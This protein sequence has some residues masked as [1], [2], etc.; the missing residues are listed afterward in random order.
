[1]KSFTSIGNNKGRGIEMMVLM[2][3][4][5]EKG[6]MVRDCPESR[7]FVFGKPKE[8]NKE[9]R[10]K[11]RAQ[12]Q[13]FAMTHRD[14]QATSDVV[15]VTFSIPGQPDFSFEGKHVDKP[16]RMIS[17][18]R[19]SSL[20]K[21]GCQGFLAY[22]LPP[23][24]EVEFTIDLAPGTTPISKAPY[25]MAPMKLKELKIQLQ[26]LLDKGFIRPS[27][28]PWGAHVLFVKKKDGSMRL[29]IDYRELNKVMAYGDQGCISVDPGK[30][31][32]VSNWRRPNIVTEIRSFLGLASY[33][34]RF[35]KGF[36]KIALPLTSLTQKGV[37]FEWSDDCECSFQE[38]K[39]RLVTA[40]ILTIPSGSRGFVVYSDA[41][42][43]G[44][45][46]VLMQHG[47]VVA[48][49]SSS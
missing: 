48:Y 11:P 3:T 43:Q 34:R 12:G 22:V 36:S 46:C 41:F 28:S 6:H 16:L 49:A 44:L 4:S 37:K 7:K 5:T 8:E 29:Y 21:K 2:V 17:A 42:H 35:I 24:R 26:E 40:P 33:Y 14:A 19:A 31:N 39:N 25:R 13:V 18:L 45:G 9:D 15:I 32:A 38:L 23:E 27:V 47:K 30:V 1:M 20:L 10:Q